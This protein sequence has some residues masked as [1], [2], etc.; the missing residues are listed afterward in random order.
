MRDE[1]TSFTRRWWSTWSARGALVVIVTWITVA[2]FAPFLANDRPLWMRAID[3]GRFEEARTSLEPMTN[4]WLHLVL[5]GE[6]A[7]RAAQG[8]HTKQ[9]YAE[10]VA[11]EKQSLERRIAIL[12][13][14]LAPEEDALR[15]VLDRF[16]R[17]VDD[18]SASPE[19]GALD[20]LARSTA[21]ELD[22]SPNVQ[23]SG[24]VASGRPVRLAGTLSMP[25]VASLGPLDA[26]ACS[27]WVALGAACFLT[28]SWRRRLLATATVFI[29][30][31]CAWPLVRPVDTG[32][33]SIKQ[34]VA[35]GDLVVERALFPPIA[36]GF[37]ETHMREAFRPPFADMS[38]TSIIDRFQDS[39]HVP[40]A[41]TALP[42]EPPDGSLWRHPL[43]TD[44]LGRDIAARLVW[45]ARISLFVGNASAVLLTLIGVALGLLAGWRGGWSDF[46]I[47]RAIEVVVCFPA[48]VLVLCAMFFVDPA[49]AP[50]LIAVAVVI[51]VVG[52]TSVARLVR[53]EVLR[54]REL[55]FVAAARALG[56]S[57]GAILRRHVL[58]NVIQPAIIAFA[59]AVGAGVLT[60]SALSFLG[61]GVQVPVPS[62]GALI[63]DS[64][65]P[66]HAW[67]WLVPGCAIF[68]VVASYNILGEALRDAL[69][70]RHER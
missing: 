29:V 23:S 13:E 32:P 38:G 56:L 1:S 62:W 67:I 61:F 16:A 7:W 3:R 51:G 4:R 69:D 2:L 20:A 58:P 53:A 46:A 30:T 41:R 34:A 52:W 14:S 40:P 57:E 36:M 25:V 22:P 15:G 47:S 37:A 70:P 65:S 59:F 28:R 5:Q 6:A 19:N 49:S 33:S 68:T 45:G 43:G 11:L 55:D 24:V 18:R 17:A 48:F 63:S 64:K 50:P 8:A 26:A 60:E 27:A 31:A 21:A 42:F 9:S 54:V 12:R 66:D 10:A 35:R 44:S 39:A